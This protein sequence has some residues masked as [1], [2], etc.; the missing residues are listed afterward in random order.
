[1][2]TRTNPQI[3]QSIDTLEQKLQ[4]IKSTIQDFLVMLELQERVNF[5]DLMGQFASLSNDF[6][7]I[8]DL[9]KKSCVSSKAEDNGLLMKSILL[10][11]SFVSLDEDPKLQL[12]TENRVVS[13]NHEIVP[14]YLR[15]QL[16]PHVIEQE[17]S[18]E[19][20]TQLRQPD[21][22]IKQIQTMNKN[23]DVL[24]S[25][26]TSRSLLS[27]DRSSYL[28]QNQNDAVTKA[29]LKTLV[30]GVMRGNGVRVKPGDNR[31]KK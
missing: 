23:I 2:D 5:P 17:R 4:Q 15:T 31:Q 6:S 16:A 19:K 20:E 14:N 3:I 30:L 21:N 10:V 26:E 9:I 12:E 25:V 13:W 7:A 27:T 11:P 24:Q 18:L 8:Q 29:E 22:V 1:M 28:P